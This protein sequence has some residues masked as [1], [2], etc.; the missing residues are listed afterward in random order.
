M[1]AP[2]VSEWSAISTR[3]GAAFLPTPRRPRGGTRRA[4]D[5]DDIRA[6]YQLGQMYFTG[7]GVAL[8]YV[9]AYVWFSLAAG[10]AP[11][12]DNRKALLE[13]RNIAAARMTPE[14]V[15]GSRTPRRRRGT[16]PRYAPAAV[17]PARYFASTPAR[18]Q[19]AMMSM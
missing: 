5:G 13:M 8:D 2:P 14:Q 10:Q 7:S 12:I 16:R 17:A 9:S 1:E 4:A 6:Q 18:L 11:L 15:A 3:R 19:V